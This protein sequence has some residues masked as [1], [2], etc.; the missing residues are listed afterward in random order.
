MGQNWPNPF[1]PS[2][3]IMIEIPSTE[4]LHL[5]VYNVLGQKVKTLLNKR[6]SPGIHRIEWDGKDERGIPAASGVY[7]YQ[8]RAGNYH[9]TKKMILVR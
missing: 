8:L 3:T 9:Q 5:T 6:Y 1:N 4:L 2:T 7:F